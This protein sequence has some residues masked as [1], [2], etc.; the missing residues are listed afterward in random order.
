MA[1]AGRIAV[2]FNSMM[3]CRGLRGQPLAR[4]FGDHLSV[5]VTDGRVL[6]AAFDGDRPVRRRRTVVVGE[7][8]NGPGS[9]APSDVAGPP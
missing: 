8:D 2:G 9:G 6:E 3:L 1:E 5:D 7:R 4:A